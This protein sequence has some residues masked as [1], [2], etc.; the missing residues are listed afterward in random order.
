[1]GKLG[2]DENIYTLFKIDNAIL[3]TSQVANEFNNYFINVVDSLLA[4][5]K[6]TEVASPDPFKY[7]IVAPTFNN[8]DRSQIANYRPISLITSFSKIF[9]ILIY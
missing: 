7:L 8:G 2:S 6:N 4:E 5:Q 3:N 1:M 9:E